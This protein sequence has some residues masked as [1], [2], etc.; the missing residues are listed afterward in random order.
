MAYEPLKELIK[1]A[2]KGNQ[3]AI[4]EVALGCSTIAELAKTGELKEADTAG[5]LLLTVIITVPVL[6]KQAQAAQKAILDMRIDKLRDKV[7]DGSF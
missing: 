7:I 6:M 3:E 2:A 4:Y 1:L 5:R